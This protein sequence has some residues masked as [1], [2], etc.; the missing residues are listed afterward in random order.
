[1]F[2]IKCRENV[3]NHTLPPVIDFFFIDY[4]VAQK[5]FFLPNVHSIKS[6]K[7]LWSMHKVY[8]LFLS[9]FIPSF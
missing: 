5:I 3:L 2:F 4:S 7:Q 1:M 9:I 8:Q 6:N